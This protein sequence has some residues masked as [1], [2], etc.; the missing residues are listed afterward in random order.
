MGLGLG[1]S[2]RLLLG[3]GRARR[4]AGDVT[5][6]REALFTAA[7]LA[8]RDSRP[9]VLAAVALALSGSGFEVALFDADQIALLEEALTGLGEEE[10][11]LRSRLAA[12]LSVALSLSGQEQRR[13][14][15][16]EEAVALARSSGGD[17]ALASA[18][19]AWCD[20]ASGPAEVE[21]RIEES[22]T[23]HRDRQA[24][25]GPGDGTPGSPAARGRP[26][27]GR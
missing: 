18:L 22:S 16:S 11:S 19:A 3:L 23:D 5:G 2:R 1:R 10:P 6:A 27:G 7:D 13:V 26:A 15:L 9:D 17:A 21:R 25:S 4:A 8:R 14:R 12:R 24:A 20:A